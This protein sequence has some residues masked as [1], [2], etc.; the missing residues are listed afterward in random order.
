MLWCLVSVTQEA[1]CLS[2]R[3]HPLTLY[4]GS[5]IMKI[6]PVCPT[7]VKIYRIFLTH[8]DLPRGMLIISLGLLVA[9]E[10]KMRAQ[11]KSLQ[12]LACRGANQI[13]VWTINPEHV[14]INAPGRLTVPIWNVILSYVQLLMG[15]W[16]RGAR[17][18]MTSPWRHSLV[19]THGKPTSLY[20][21]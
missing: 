16:P 20:A 9:L 19:L 8:F 10:F 18:P 1:R 21:S 12:D 3:L 6:L 13:L 4:L 7:S 15:I 17:V 2:S 11:K 14:T 5:S